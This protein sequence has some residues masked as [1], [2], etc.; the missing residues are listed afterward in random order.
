MRTQIAVSFA[1]TAASA[2]RGGAAT[3]RNEAVGSSE[4]HVTAGEDLQKPRHGIQ[5]LVL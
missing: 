4:G 1:A 3:G 5:F 2:G